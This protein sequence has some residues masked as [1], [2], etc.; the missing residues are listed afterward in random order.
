MLA[1][2]EMQLAMSHGKKVIMYTGGRHV[3]A[4]V[5]TMLLNFGELAV[6]YVSVLA[7]LNTLKDEC[8]L[9]PL[10]EVYRGDGP[11]VFVSYSHKDSKEVAN[12]IKR[13]VKIGCRVWFDEG[14]DPGNEWPEEIAKALQGCRQFIVFISGSAIV[15]KNV[16]NEIAYA[17]SINKEFLAIYL[18]ETKLPPGLMLSMGNIQAIMKYRMNDELYEKKVHRSVSSYCLMNNKESPHS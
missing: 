5:G 2:R 8:H 18:E 16:R 7:K 3:P 1:S 17:L 13:L 15:S 11:Y 4:L 9:A 6:T 14:I 12:E 10:G